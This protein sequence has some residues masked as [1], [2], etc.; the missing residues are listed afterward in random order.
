MLYIDDPDASWQSLMFEQTG[1]S[2]FEALEFERQERVSEHLEETR[3]CD[4]FVLFST[5]DPSA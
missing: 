1:K 2:T 4:S 3:Q 5:N